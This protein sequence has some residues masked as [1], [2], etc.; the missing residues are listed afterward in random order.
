MPCCVAKLHYR[1]CLHT[2]WFKLGCSHGC[3]AGCKRER[4]LLVAH[5]EYLWTCE[6]CRLGCRQDE[7]DLRREEYRDWIELIDARRDLSAACKRAMVVCARDRA[8]REARQNN[9]RVAVMQRE[10]ARVGRWAF[11]YSWAL[12]HATFS[13]SALTRFRWAKRSQA[14]FLCKLWDVVVRSNIVDSEETLRVTQRLPAC[15]GK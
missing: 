12:C 6:R 15:V 5:V 13:K 3:R 10:Q 14:L 1:G 11:D 4:R 2:T 8:V 7:E 9:K